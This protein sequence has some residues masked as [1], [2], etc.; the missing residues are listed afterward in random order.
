MH[1]WIWVNS[2]KDL[3]E[4]ARIWSKIEMLWTTNKQKHRKTT[5]PEAKPHLILSCNQ[6]KIIRPSPSLPKWDLISMASLRCANNRPGK[7]N[8]TASE[9]KQRLMEKQR[10]VK[11]QRGT[12]F[13]EIKK[14]TEETWKYPSDEG[15]VY[16][17]DDIVHLK[18]FGSDERAVGAADVSNVVQ[19]QIVQDQDV[20]VVS[21][22]SVVQMTS[23]VIIHLK[24]I[25]K[26]CSTPKIQWDITS[27]I[28]GCKSTT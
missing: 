25:E 8:Y 18:E 11:G 21:F 7:I 3:C 9:R 28:R 24:N 17:L 15:G 13:R 1:R 23:H 2:I 20:P 27:E 12:G 22:Q 16:L 10:D 6:N 14:E 19:P 4:R 26:Q 5:R